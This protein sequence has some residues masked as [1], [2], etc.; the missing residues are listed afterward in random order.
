MLKEAAQARFYRFGEYEVDSA[1]RLLL[2]NGERVTLTPKAF[3]V[4]LALLE[5]HG[6]IVS[7]DELLRIVWP[8][9]VVEEI[10]LTRNISVL[11]KTL[12]EKPDEHNYIV[13][14]PGTGY[15]FVAAVERADTPGGAASEK[16][17]A[18]RRWLL[19]AVMAL[20]A[21]AGLIAWYFRP[22]E[23]AAVAARG[24]PDELPRLR[25]QPG[26]LA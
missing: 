22:R 2:R 13:T 19:M 14:V 18:G 17:R 11:R 24:S 20:L 10:S 5:R 21:V 1:Q 16:A 15:R 6:E 8:D 3:D 7:K 12:G 23:R 4:L 9:T 25:A 26:D